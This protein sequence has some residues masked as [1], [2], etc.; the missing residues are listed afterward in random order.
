M[1]LDITAYS[2][3]KHIGQHKKD[4][5]FCYYEN[6]V[7]AFAYSVFAASFRG[8]PILGTRDVENTSFIDGGCFEVTEATESHGFRAGSYSGYNRW[9]RDLASQFNPDTNPDQPFYE[10]IYFAD[11]EGSIGPDAAKD[12]LADFQKHQNEYAQTVHEK[13]FR[14]KYADWTRA[15][16][17]ASNGG[18]VSFH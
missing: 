5:D 8:I 6:H 17:L 15:F 14:E 2:N 12:L 18:L 9:R 10:L 11:N 16:E 7:Q 13:Y 1:G 4:T 3:L